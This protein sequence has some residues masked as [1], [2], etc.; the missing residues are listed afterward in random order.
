MNIFFDLC[1]I[2]LIKYICFTYLVLAQQQ[3]MKKFKSFVN[4]ELFL[5]NI[6]TDNQIFL[7]IKIIQ[8]IIHI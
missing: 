7:T 1:M 3:N 2:L 8:N 4:H 5:T 6:I